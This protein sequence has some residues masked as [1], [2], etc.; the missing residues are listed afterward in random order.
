MEFLNKRLFASP[1]FSHRFGYGI[2]YA[3]CKGPTPPLSRGLSTNWSF[4]DHPCW[5][6]VNTVFSGYLVNRTLNYPFSSTTRSNGEYEPR[7]YYPFIP[8][9]P[10]LFIS[11]FN[12]QNS[13]SFHTNNCSIFI[14]YFRKSSFHIS[15]KKE[16]SN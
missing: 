13:L 7:G 5:T 6:P 11:V 14:T 10:A 15:I 12:T 4:F 16:F 3:H 2:P 8:F 1:M 9:F